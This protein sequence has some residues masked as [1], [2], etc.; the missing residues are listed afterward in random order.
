MRRRLPAYLF[1]KG[2][3]FQRLIAAIARVTFAPRRAA[4]V[5]ILC[6]GLLFIGVV[7]L[8]TVFS[9]MGTPARPQVPE[10]GGTGTFTTFDA[11][12]AG[13]AA[14]QGTGGTNINAAGDIAGIYVTAPNV[15][16][17]FVRA[18]ST[19][20]ITA[21]D[22][23]NTGTSLNQG[24]FPLSINTAGDIAGA[25]F[26]GNNAYHSFVR[27]GATGAITEF[28]VPSAPTST[29]HRGTVALRINDSG[30]ITGM[31]VDSN[32]VRHGF[33]RTVANGTATITTFD[34]AAA[35]T[36]AGQ[37][38]IPINIDAAG[39]VTGFYVDANGLF[40]GF[41]R[42]SN[43]TITAPIDAPGASTVATGK[44]FSF[45][46]TLPVGLD[47]SGDIAG[48]L[49]DA[50]KVMHGFVRAANGTITTFN[51]SGAGTTG[52]FPG[53]IP[54]SINGT[55]DIAG[56]YEDANGVNHG[57]IRTSSGVISAP[58]D[59]PGASTSGMISGTVALGINATDDITGTYVDAN[60]V[61]H[62]F[63]LT[64]GTVA[65]P[66]FT[67]AQGTYST[68]QSVT[69]SDAT[70]G[71]TI[72]YTTDGTAPTTSSTVYSGAISVKSTETIEAMAAAT[73]LSD[74][75]VASATYT[76]VPAAATP[77]FSP[78]AGT[79][80]SVQSVKIS[81]TTTGAT[82][83]YTTD[84]TAPTTSSNVYSGAITVNA[85]ETIEAIAAATGFSNSAVASAAYT[86]NLPAPDFQVSVNPTTLTIVAGQSG[87]A[88]FTVTPEN[89]FNSKVSF[90]CNGLPAEATCTFSPVSVTPNGAAVTTTLTV[91][92]T[93]ASTLIQ[94]PMPSSK[95]PICALLFPLLAILFGFCA[96]RK[97]GRVALQV[98]SL[99]ILLAA[100]T[101]LTSC[102]GG[103]SSGGNPGTP[104]GTTTA[105]VSASTAAG[106]ATHAA[107]LTI[108][109]TQ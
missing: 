39:N 73:G 80:T 87:Q 20:A 10:T 103:K 36:A 72:Y 30:E 79:Y 57:F 22:A 23:Q 109:I 51:V 89:G 49:S 29:K 21:F 64:S 83:Y 67:P 43:G 31:Y 59:A 97:R 61:F 90:T 91:A 15:A 50:S 77:T 32:D 63:V 65:T 95:R 69:I 99:L 17:G 46:G 48:I 78:A 12:G 66:T 35:G 6:L 82:I 68:A 108:I 24:T 53:T 4:P 71:A 75:A 9:A 107:A 13:T 34:V 94:P 41:L 1:P 92:T 5:A 11:P 44:G 62:G 26:D 45:G 28:D 38:T 81:E 98:L 106:G 88:T 8:T 105:S 101:G 96:R 2:S 42:A 55:G 33:V 40:H 93:A 70:A 7:C 102:G 74:S 60:E 84:G 14:L 104:V 100:A 52:L 86:I 56:L 58:L 76:I 25:Y 47:A 85:T 16:H 54:T 27:A 3:I 37:G 19:G 18:A